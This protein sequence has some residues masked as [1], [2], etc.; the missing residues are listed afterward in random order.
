MRVIGAF[1]DKREAE[2][3]VFKKAVTDE[4]AKWL[5]PLN[6]RPDQIKVTDIGIGD[7]A[8]NFYAIVLVTYKYSEAGNWEELYKKL[9]LDGIAKELYKNYKKL[10]PKNLEV[11]S[12]EV[13]PSPLI[14]FT[15]TISG[16]KLK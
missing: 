7:V 6:I 16:I 3:P 8:D 11:N 9:K 12:I 10:K 14:G 5:K 1:F 4:A 15:I 13:N 2:K